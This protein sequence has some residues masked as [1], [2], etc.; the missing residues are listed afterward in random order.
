M[1]GGHNEHGILRSM[2]LATLK[3]GS[4]DGQLMVVSR[5]LKTAHLASHIAH[6]LQQ[7]LDDWNFVCP[8]LEA[9][10]EA[11]NTGRSKNPFD[12]NPAHCMA[13]L[14]RAFQWADGSAYVSHFELLMQARGE[15]LPDFYYDDPCIYQGGADDFIGPCDFAYFGSEEWGI[16]FEAELAVV[17]TDIPAGSSAEDAKH[18]IV[19]LGLLNDWSLRNLIAGE[20]Q[21][22][23]GFFQSKPATSF[24]PVFVTPDELGD[25]WKDTTLHLPVIVH[26][27]GKKVGQANAGTDVVFNFARLLEHAAK[28]RSLRAGSIV[29]GGTISNK[30]VSAGYSCIAE[31]RAREMISEGKAL[32]DYMRFGDRVKI[33]VLDRSG[34]SVFGC[35]DQQVVALAQK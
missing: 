11:V 21:K 5:N 27:N 22:H 23:F 10:A 25:S 14:P 29:G 9:L 4:R 17:T 12:F 34:Q 13:P 33:E 30:S 2:K 15:T 28:T 24:A 31:A 8:Q 1:L 3:D 35:I 6:N 16:D 18:G 7:A 20:W 19:L 26:W 32:S